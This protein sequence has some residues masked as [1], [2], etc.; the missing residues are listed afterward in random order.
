MQKVKYKNLDYEN[1]M[2]K[3]KGQHEIFYAI[4]IKNRQCELFILNI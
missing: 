2:G 4:I 1:K 3:K